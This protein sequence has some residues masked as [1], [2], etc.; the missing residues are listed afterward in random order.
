MSRNTNTLRLP[1]WVVSVYPLLSSKNGFTRFFYYPPMT[2]VFLH[3]IANV[4]RDLPL[5]D[6]EKITVFIKNLECESGIDFEDVPHHLPIRYN[7]NCNW[8]IKNKTP[9]QII[10]QCLEDYVESSEYNESDHNNVDETK[11]KKQDEIDQNDFDDLI[12][13]DVLNWEDESPESI[14]EGEQMAAYWKKTWK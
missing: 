5:R 12:S 8:S 13:N 11:V 9:R 4:L 6:N 7:C 1:K 14:L 3:L 10:E 2:R